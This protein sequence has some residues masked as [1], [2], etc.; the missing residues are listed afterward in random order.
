[1]K[2]SLKF[3]CFDFLFLVVCF[4]IFSVTFSKYSN[5]VETKVNSKIATPV[6]SIKS[7]DYKNIDVLENNIVSYNFSVKNYDNFISDVSFR[8]I[9]YFEYSQ[10]NPPIILNLYK[11]VNGKEEKIELNREP[12]SKL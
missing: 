2:K 10:E 3:F 6:I 11:D 7:E 9:L 1:M 4:I 8:Y 12:N 5:S